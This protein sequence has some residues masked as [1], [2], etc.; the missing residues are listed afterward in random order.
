MKGGIPVLA[1]PATFFAS[2]AFYKIK[3][4]NKTVSV[5]YSIAKQCQ[6]EG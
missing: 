1:S 5:T 6:K 3:Q 4:V 2:G